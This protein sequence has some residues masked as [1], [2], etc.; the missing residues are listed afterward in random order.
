M[1][2]HGNIY[3]WCSVHNMC[4][5]IV[6]NTFIRFESLHGKSLYDG[7]VITHPHKPAPYK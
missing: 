2:S 5:P 4:M 1:N 6:L 3:N 7:G